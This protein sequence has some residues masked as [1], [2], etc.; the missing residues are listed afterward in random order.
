MKNYF[1]LF[2]LQ[3][4]FLIFFLQQSKSQIAVAAISQDIVIY[5]A[6]KIH[7]NDCNYIHYLTT[8]KKSNVFYTN[9]SVLGFTKSVNIDL[10][11]NLY[12]DYE[13]FE[14]AYIFNENLFIITTRRPK[15]SEYEEVVGYIY[16]LNGEK[17]NSKVLMKKNHRV[18]DRIKYYYELSG[19]KSK[20]VIGHIG[21][22]LTIYDSNLEEAY[23][24]KHKF[25][26]G[27]KC[28]LFTDLGEMIYYYDANYC[29]FIGDQA[30]KERKT[31]ERN[32]MFTYYDE[33]S[34]YYEENQLKLEINEPKQLFYTYESKLNCL[35]AGTMNKSSE[36]KSEF[37]FDIMRYWPYKDSTELMS[38]VLDDNDFP[39]PILEAYYLSLSRYEAK[40][41]NAEYPNLVLFLQ[42]YTIAEDGSI[43]LL[44]SKMA[45]YKHSIKNEV[46]DFFATF[47]LMLVKITNGKVK[48]IE[49]LPRRFNDEMYRFR[50]KDFKLFETEDYLY[51]IMKDHP[52]NVD[53]I[54]SGN[55]NRIYFPP[56]D[57]PSLRI[58]RIDKK[59]GEAEHQTIYN[60]KSV[61][62]K[63]YST[64]YF[65]PL[66]SYKL[67]DNT[68]IL[69]KYNSKKYLKILKITLL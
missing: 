51:L 62:R 25:I 58:S 36:D 11:L 16:K 41:L 29:S 68:I 38:C 8:D 10:K 13:N 49:Y 18:N 33:D 4:I 15:K 19:N 47:D 42:Q 32:F 64:K 45:F 20:I 22:K 61:N 30:V 46:H 48:W 6:K 40:K 44:F 57:D 3:F 56:S 27:T 52:E 9:I 28:H 5:D 34:E 23:S 39:T 65:S 55:S 50:N 54:K 67:D 69:E 21:G 63:K 53:L 1:I 7:A 59:T 35:L 60:Y 12:S 37:L 2:G 17:V 24:L 66:T 31:K 14:I 43:F 26:D